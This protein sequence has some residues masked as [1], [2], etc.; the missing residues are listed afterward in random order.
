[1]SSNSYFGSLLEQL[2]GRWQALGRRE[3]L[4]LLVCGAFLSFILVYYVMF[5][6]AWQGRERLRTD[7]PVMRAKVATMESLADE[8]KTLRSVR[9]SKLSAAAVRAELQRLLTAAKLDRQAKVDA[10][11][12]LIKVKFDQVR[13]DAMNDWVFEVARDVKLRV[14]DVSVT[15]DPQ[16]GKVAATVSLQ[17]PGADN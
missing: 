1:M 9:A 15:K 4:F 3:R 17:R 11:S 13:F 16:A 14:V 2:I 10:G 6:P 5:R 12:D 7:L 8:V